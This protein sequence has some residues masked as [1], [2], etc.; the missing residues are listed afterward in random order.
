MTLN[1][2]EELLNS[3][4][5]IIKEEL[6]PVKVSIH[7]MEDDIN[8]MKGDINGLKDGFDNMKVDID[9]MKGDIKSIKTLQ[10]EDHLILKA[11]EHKAEINKAEHDK[12]INNLAHLNGKITNMKNTL[13]SIKEDNKS[14]IEVL[15]EHEISIR[16]LK[17][18]PV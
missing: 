7:N 17:R 14:I 5:A 6:K 8:S 12:I 9:S 4:R 11:L 3:I 10:E 13:K 2:N 15:G 18:R 16:T 1:M